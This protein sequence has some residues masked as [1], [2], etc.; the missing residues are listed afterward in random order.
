M[1]EET[2]DIGYTLRDQIV[3]E[4]KESIANCPDN[5]IYCIEPPFKYFIF[6]RTGVAGTFTLVTDKGKFAVEITVKPIEK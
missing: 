4:L 5:L 1:S 2:K 3:D 6:L